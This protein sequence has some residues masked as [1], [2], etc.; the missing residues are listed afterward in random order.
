ML[1]F[2]HWI[3]SKGLNGICGDAQRPFLLPR[4]KSFF[5]NSVI[6]F[7]ATLEDRKQELAPTETM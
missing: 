4:G 6:S 2:L 1:T 3:D 7:V 5:S